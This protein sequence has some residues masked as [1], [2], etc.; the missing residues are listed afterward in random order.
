MFQMAAPRGNDDVPVTPEALMS[1]MKEMMQLIVRNKEEMSKHSGGQQ[2]RESTPPSQGEALS[3]DNK[4]TTIQKLTRF[5]KFAPKHF[6][7]AITPSDA[8][9]WLE[10][11]EA[12]LEAVHIEDEDQ[13]L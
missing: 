11:L 1:T 2:N 3:K 5:K 6:K 4:D 8:E 12:V 13:M 7:E 10:E 9:D